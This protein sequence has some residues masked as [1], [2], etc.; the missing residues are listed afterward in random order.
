MTSD[1]I[2]LNKLSSQTYIYI[3]LIYDTAFDLLVSHS[4][5]PKQR[6]TPFEA[7]NS[8]KPLLRYTY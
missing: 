6:F 2:V 7:C 3:F 5:A 1:S 8:E 4:S